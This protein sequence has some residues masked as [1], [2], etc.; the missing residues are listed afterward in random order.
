MKY[1]ASNKIDV[2]ASH[3]I[4]M[5]AMRWRVETFYRDTKPDLGL[6]DCELGHAAG[7]SRQR[8]LLMLAYSLLKLGA[9]DRA[10][11]TILAHASSL[12]NDVKR[13]FHEDVQNLLSWALSSPNYST[14]ELVH[15]IEGIFHLTCEV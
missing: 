5:Y 6:G 4:G 11:G 9:A 14:D 8:H 15:Q 12:R 2:P 7:A 1:I 3:L 13:S 10:F